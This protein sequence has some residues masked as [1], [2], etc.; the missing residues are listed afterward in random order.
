MFSCHLFL[1]YQCI[2]RISWFLC[3]D[4]KPLEDNCH[5]QQECDQCP[6][7][8]HHVISLF[9]QLRNLPMQELCLRS[10]RRKTHDKQKVIS[11]AFIIPGT[12]GKISPID[13]ETGNEIS[14]YYQSIA[15]NLPSAN[16]QFL[17]PEQTSDIHGVI[18]CLQILILALNAKWNI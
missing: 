3:N 7:A 15:S 18:Y 12:K 4:S 6:K 9:F 1:A 11:Y 13:T 14:L 17:S 5:L 10:L 16:S 2:S 8:P